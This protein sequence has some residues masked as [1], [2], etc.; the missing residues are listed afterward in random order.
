MKLE[1]TPGWN[2][3]KQIFVD[4]WDEF[5]QRHLRY[6][7]GY[8]DGLVEKML[9]CGNP[10]QIGYVEY[11]CLDCG[12]GKH[13]VAMSC[14]SALCLRCAKVYVD[15]WVSQVSNML[16]EGVIYRHT[17]LTVPAMLRDTFYQNSSNS[18]NRIKPSNHRDVRVAFS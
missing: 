7:R 15:N 14:K 3:F 18:R 1:L 5:K 10:E 4:H 6:D 16:H 13:L 17:V 2:V 11:R 9:G 12:Q 8:Y